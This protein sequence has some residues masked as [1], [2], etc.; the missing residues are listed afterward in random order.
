MCVCVYPLHLRVTEWK[1]VLLGVRWAF[2]GLRCGPLTISSEL[3]QLIPS[4]IRPLL[5]LTSIPSSL[6]LL[7]PLS[8]CTFFVTS[9]FGSLIAL[10]SI[11]HLSESFSWWHTY[12]TLSSLQASLCT[13]TPL[14]FFPGN[15]CILPISS[16]SSLFW[17]SFVP[18]LLSILTCHHL[19]SLPSPSSIFSGEKKSLMCILLTSRFT[20]KGYI[21]FKIYI[22]CTSHR[23]FETTSFTPTT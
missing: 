20:I 12:I 19:F 11:W 2:Q 21:P 15:S 9:Y 8:V 17:T 3:S 5:C 10:L 13:F 6:L 4:F 14:L 7:L 23:F 22:K 1:D 18:R 16:S